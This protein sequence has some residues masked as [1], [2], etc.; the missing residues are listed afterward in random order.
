MKKR[1]E[2]PE[3][4]IMNFEDEMATDIPSSGEEPTDVGGDN[5]WSDLP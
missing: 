4:V 5:P 3:L 2:Y 1:Y